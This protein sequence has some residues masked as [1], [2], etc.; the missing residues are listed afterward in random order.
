MEVSEARITLSIPYIAQSIVIGISDFEQG[1][2]IEIAGIAGT[3]P[4]NVHTRIKNVASCFS[5]KFLIV[6]RIPS[7][8]VGH[9]SHFID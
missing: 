7:R 1:L 2:V 4:P 6:I 3:I 5:A 9:N 8:E